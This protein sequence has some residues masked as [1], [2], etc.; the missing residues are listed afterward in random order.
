MRRGRGKQKEEEGV[1]NNNNLEREG[2][3]PGVGRQY[4]GHP[5]PSPRPFNPL[6]PPN[7]HTPHTLRHTLGYTPGSDSALRGEP[8]GSN[9][10]LIASPGGK[11]SEEKEIA[12]TVN[13]Q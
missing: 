8:Q 3:K 6:H 5:A 10:P 1:S 4:G 2:R 9:W 11:G 12:S 7:T 13:V